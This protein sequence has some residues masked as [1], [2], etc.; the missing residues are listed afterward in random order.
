MFER[1]RGDYLLPMVFFERAVAVHFRGVIININPDGLTVVSNDHNI[2]AL[3]DKVLMEKEFLLEFNF[4]GMDTDGIKGVINKIRP[5]L[6]K[7]HEIT[8]DFT[9]TD[10]DPITRRDINRTLQA[11]KL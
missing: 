10:I 6:F 8:M 7:G 11:Q 9:F 1:K 4:F 5:G 2:L 3:D